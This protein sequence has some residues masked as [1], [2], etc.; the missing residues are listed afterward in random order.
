MREIFHRRSIRKYRDIPVSAEQLEKLLRAGMAAPSAGNGR[1]WS[2]LVIESREGRDKF[3]AAHDASG[4]VKTAP[5]LIIVCARVQEEKYF[6]EGFWIQDCSAATENILIEA[7]H[8]G[9]GSLWMGI[10]P[11]QYRID[12]LRKAFHIPEEV[13]PFSAVAVGVS[14]FAKASIDRYM[15]EYVFYEFYGNSYHQEENAVLD[16][17]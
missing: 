4:A 10:Y 14:E 6:P 12:K 3:M 17:D 7:V 5:L 16:K 15:R 1:E 13:V 11:C 9:L 8:L 2:F